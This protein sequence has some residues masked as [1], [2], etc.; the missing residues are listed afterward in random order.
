MYTGVTYIG[1]YLYYYWEMPIMAE[2]DENLMIIFNDL[3]TFHRQTENYGPYIFDRDLYFVLYDSAVFVV[4]DP[5]DP[6]SAL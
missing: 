2:G 5:E 4:N 6:Y 1:D 3:A